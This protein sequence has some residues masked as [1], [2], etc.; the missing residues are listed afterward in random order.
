MLAII[1]SAL[2]LLVASG[3]YAESS[4]TSVHVVEPGDT[5]WQIAQDAGTD[6]ASLAKLNGLQE[7]DVI[8]V[9]Q[10]LKLPGAAAPA[11]GSASAPGRA[12][13]YTVAD[14]DTLSS[15]ALQLG[16]TSAALVD[17][18]HL[19]DPDRLAIGTELIAPGQA[20]SGGV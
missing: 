1:S 7:D 14:G 11:S 2:S 9:G 20:S 16:T 3:A 17:A 18:N 6:V 12:R 15:I 5:L 4:G 10:S 19:D 8:A 13:T